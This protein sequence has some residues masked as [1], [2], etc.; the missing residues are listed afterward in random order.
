MILASCAVSKSGNKKT[1]TTAIPETPAN[2]NGVKPFASV[3]TKEMITQQGLF[4]VH[5]TPEKDTILFEIDEHLIGRDILAINRIRKVSSGVKMYSGEELCNRTIT[6]EKG[7]NET[8]LL[9]LRYQTSLADTASAIYRAVKASNIN[10]IIATLPIRA[11]GKNN[12]SYVV[13][14]TAILKDPGSFVNE[15]E[16]DINKFLT[17]AAMKEHTV[18][19]IRTYP[20]NVEIAISKNGTADKTLYSKTP[21]PASLE[22]N[23]SFIALPEVPMQQRFFDP[24]VGYFAD[25]YMEYA[26]DQQAVKKRQFINR[27]RLEPKPADRARY[28]K[29]ELVEPAKPIV[30]YIDPATPKQWRPYLIQGINDWRPAFEQAGFKNAITGKEWPEGDSAMNLEDVRY[31]VLRYAPSEI[32]NAYGPNTHDP[33]SGEIIQTNIIWYH[34]IMDLLHDWYLIQAGPNDPRA[35]V[36][37]FDEALMGQLIRFVSSH[38][39]GHTL[40]LRHN[41]GS[42]SQTPVDSLRSISYLQKNGHTASIMDYAR[43]NY[44]AQPEDSI[45]AALLYP[46]VNDYDKWAI[47]WGYKLT[48][49]RTPVADSKIMSKLATQRLAANNRLWFG[50]G[51]S[52]DRPVMDPRCQ[53]EDLGDNN[54]RA[55][56]LGIKNLKRVMAEMENWSY[57][58]G[59]TAE[60]LRR[61]YDRLLGQFLAYLQQVSMSIGGIQYQLPSNGSDAPAFIPLPKEKQL[62]ALEYINRELFTTPTWLVDSTFLNKCMLPYTIDYVEDMQ[63]KSVNTVFNPPFFMRLLRTAKQFGEDRTITIPEVLATIRKTVWADLQ[64]NV[65]KIDAYHRNMQKAYVGGLFTIAMDEERGVNETDAITI[66]ADEITLI[67]DMI[68]KAIPAAADNLTSMH[69]HDLA[70]RIER[71]SAHQ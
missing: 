22:T 55:N 20:A 50:D 41:F 64:N 61:I 48:G 8:I 29:G 3:V 56:A 11:Y 70:E 43:F 28:E 25:S 52:E 21:V 7:P 67:T 18:T 23:T 58:E 17:V 12:A 6:F 13:D 37:H 14:V 2:K 65:V 4:T 36:A 40:G 69:L 57:E 32:A 45:P 42:S 60:N 46:R 30:I 66:A 38:E 54:A 68:R 63:I 10:G 47:E 15:A 24:R 51:E 9:K 35:R 33:R 59:H 19:D 39:V 31:S 16:G 26:D 27:W 53:T 5:S 34:N 44:V 71:L 49:A 62:E 1:A